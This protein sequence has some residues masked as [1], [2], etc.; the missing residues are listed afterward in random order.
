MLEDQDEASAEVKLAVT[1]VYD[2]FAGKWQMSSERQRWIEYWA[3]CLS[4]F[5]PSEISFVADYCIKEHRRPPVPVEFKVLCSRLRNSKPLSEPI[6]SRIE[7]LAYLILANEEFQEASS[8][9]I[10]D[11]CLIASAISSLN[12]YAHLAYHSKEAGVRDELNSRLNMFFDE[13]LLW[14]LD[15][16]EGRGY[17]AKVFAK[18]GTRGCV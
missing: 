16:K 3:P 11:A 15:A 10:S 17:W 13:A 2:K 14:Q 4:E 5:T 9:D 7:R 6:V 18:E 12:S 8:S 1:E